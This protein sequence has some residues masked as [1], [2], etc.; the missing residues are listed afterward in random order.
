MSTAVLFAIDTLYSDLLP[1]V[2]DV[3]FLKY[4]YSNY[5]LNK[6]LSE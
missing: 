5:K 1:A 4:L 6:G 3:T 2:S